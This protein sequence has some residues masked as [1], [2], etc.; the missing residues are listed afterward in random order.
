MPG[1]FVNGAYGLTFLYVGV[2]VASHTHE[3]YEAGH[4]QAMI[5][6]AFAHSAVFELVASVAMPSLIIH[7]V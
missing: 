7:Q 5:A 1:W 3:A 6:R 2:A 4:S